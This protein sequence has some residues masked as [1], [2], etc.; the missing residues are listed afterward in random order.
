MRDVD[1]PVEAAVVEGPGAPDARGAVA[2]VGMEE[3][4]PVLGPVQLDLVGLVL[5]VPGP[6]VV[7][8]VEQGMMMMRRWG[9]IRGRRRRLVNPLIIA[10]LLEVVVSR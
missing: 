1:L 4:D 2:P 8:P 7:A 5:G 10:G 6:V 9:L 3:R